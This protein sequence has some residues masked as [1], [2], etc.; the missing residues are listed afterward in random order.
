[1]FTGGSAVCCID[2][3]SSGLDPLS[4]RK[5]WNILL[6][7]RG[8]RTLILTT[9][10][11]DEADLLADRMFILSKGTLRA[12]GTSVELKEKLGGGYRIHLHLPPGQS[13]PHIE[14][15]ERYD[16]FGQSTYTASTSGEAAHIIRYLDK[17]GLSDYQLSGPTIEEVFLQLAD[18]AKSP[19][20]TIVDEKP[21]SEITEVLDENLGEAVTPQARLDVLGLHTGKRIS[22]FQQCWV[23][24]RKRYTILRRNYLPYIC[25]FL[26][27]V[28]A[29]GLVTLFLKDF[30]A[31]GCSPVDN[32]RV[33]DVESLI[34]VQR[35]NLVIGP[36]SKVSLMTARA[37]FQ[38]QLPIPIPLDTDVERVIQLV[39]TLD[40]F[41][42][43]IDTNFTFVRPAGIWLGDDTSPPTVAYLGDRGIYFGIFGHNVL[44]ILLT[45]VSIST[46]YSEFDIPWAPSTGKSLQLVVYFGL[47][48]AAYPGFFALYPTIERI[49]N[50][51]DLEYSNGVRSLPL[52]LAY[53]GFDF[54]FVL[55]SSALSIIIFATSSSAWYHVGYL[56]L[57][58]ALYGMASILLAYVVSLFARTTLS[59]FAFTAA[60]QAVLLLI[61]LIGYLVTLTYAVCTS[62]FPDLNSID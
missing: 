16:T 21:R 35:L 17:H 52:W 1:M 55:V 54:L 10:F 15:A 34:T 30:R 2:E 14:G 44:D 27:P 58:L 51:R 28:I 59:A 13:S 29:A 38:Q 3:V 24:F 18:E 5:I 32:S 47:A 41:N 40:Q 36:S 37:L 19:N 12:Q 31:V 22:P 57:I 48:L 8:S 23:L 46:Q 20:N 11:L 43:Y 45:N 4:R 50:I 60:A 39:D 42:N 56:F 6:A 7:E 26:L 53:L 62:P 9:H 25:A 49:R 33:S 61:Y